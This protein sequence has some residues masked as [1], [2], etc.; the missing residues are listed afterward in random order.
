LKK[1]GSAGLYVIV[2]ALSWWICKLEAGSD[3]LGAWDIVDDVTWLLSSVMLA[4]PPSGVKRASPD[5]ADAESDDE[6]PP[7][8]CVTTTMSHLIYFKSSFFR[9]VKA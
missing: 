7:S 6:S 5:T 1:G 2:M 8:K 9:R 3:E 4:T